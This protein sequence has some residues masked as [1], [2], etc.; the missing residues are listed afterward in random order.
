MT[1]H[2]FERESGQGAYLFFIPS[3]ADWHMNKVPELRIVSTTRNGC[4]RIA[5]AIVKE[6]FPLLSNT[7][8]LRVDGFNASRRQLLSPCFDRLSEVRIR[9]NRPKLYVCSIWSLASTS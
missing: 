7:S 9:G 8:N 2:A 5:R 3:G 1:G 6:F 4:R